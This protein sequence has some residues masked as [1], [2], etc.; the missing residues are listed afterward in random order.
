MTT[1]SLVRELSTTPAH[2]ITA[3]SLVN[4]RDAHG[5]PPYPYSVQTG[6]YTIDQLGGEAC[7][8]CG[9]WFGPAG[10]AAPSPMFHERVAEWQ[11]Y[12]HVVCPKVGATR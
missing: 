10:A 5:L 1:A 11:V 3:I 6:G 7:G 12:R 2:L 9:V 8:V 4:A